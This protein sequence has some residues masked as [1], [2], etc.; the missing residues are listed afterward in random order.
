MSSK[1]IARRL[2]HEQ[3]EEEKQLWRALRDRQFAG[4]KFRRQHTSGD[5]ILDF[6]CVEAKLAVE[7]DGFHHGLPDEVQK[8]EART[9]KLAEENIEV[10]RFWN[11]QW[12]ENRDGCLIEI[13]NA[14]RRRTGIVQIR[15]KVEKQRFIPAD[16][17]HIQQKRK[18]TASPDF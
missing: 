3:T 5:Y 4:F 14:L 15:N 8:D 9:K 18:P 12:R 17:Q 7:L 13:W 1:E 16:L 2:R 6:Y 11:H 10:L